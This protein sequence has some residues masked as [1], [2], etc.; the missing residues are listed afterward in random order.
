MHCALTNFQW[1]TQNP[2]LVPQLLLVTT[3]LNS[4]ASF[5]NFLILCFKKKFQEHSLSLHLYKKYKSIHRYIQYHAF[6]L[7]PSLAEVH[8][9][10]TSQTQPAI[11]QCASM[12]EKSGP[13]FFFCQVFILEKFRLHIISHFR[14]AIHQSMPICNAPRTILAGWIKD[15]DFV[16]TD[17]DFSGHKSGHSAA[18]RHEMT[19]VRPSVRPS[20]RPTTTRTGRRQ[21][22]RLI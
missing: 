10:P 14:W 4:S 13:R 6:K 16:W 2:I 12:L 1:Q 15:A 8:S 21:A 11:A 3:H 19:V 20:G 17:N 7:A 9:E 18:P 5:L 22:G